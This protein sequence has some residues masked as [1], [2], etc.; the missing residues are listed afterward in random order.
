M[1]RIFI[2][3]VFHRGYTADIFILETPEGTILKKY[4]AHKKKS[5]LSTINIAR[6][7]QKEIDGIASLGSVHMDGV[8][9]PRIVE[10]DYHNLWYSQEYFSL[11]PFNKFLIR[12]SGSCNPNLRIFDLF[13]KLGAYLANFHE[14]SGRLHGDLN[15]KNILFGNDF[16]FICDPFLLERQEREN[17]TFDLFRVVN[18][19]Y[20]YNIF[21]RPFIRKKD[22]LIK[23]FLK[24]YFESSEASFDKE[25]FKKEMIRHLK[26]MN[27]VMSNSVIGYLKYFII[28]ILNNKLIKSLE[29][30]KVDWLS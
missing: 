26:E 29:R 21:V 30:D 27:V 15:R 20:P 6:I 8:V 14:K 11:V 24:G 23:V 16:I 28:L 5:L 4:F 9:T 13:Y 2:E 7:F 12:N 25:E 1:S 17:Y 19:F 10:V 18:N 22:E 3:K